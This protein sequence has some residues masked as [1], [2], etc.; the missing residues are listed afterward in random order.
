MNIWLFFIFFYLFFFFFLEIV[1]E[2]PS[3]NSNKES[4]CTFSEIYNR[5]G[6]TSNGGNSSLMF[7]PSEK[8]YTLKGKIKGVL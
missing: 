3:Y 7:S 5:N 8:E 6:Y 1:H 4:N 2:L